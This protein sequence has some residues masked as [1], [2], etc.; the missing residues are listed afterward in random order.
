MRPKRRPGEVTPPPNAESVNIDGVAGPPAYHIPMP[1]PTRVVPV[2][3]GEWVIGV[4]SPP[5]NP[6]QFAAWRETRRITELQRRVRRLERLVKRLMGDLV[7]FEPRSTRDE[8]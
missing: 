5:M 7:S 2:A 8:F 1:P 6:E 4:A 3:G